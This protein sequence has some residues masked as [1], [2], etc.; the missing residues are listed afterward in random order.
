MTF[1]SVVPLLVVI[2]DS[3]P[4]IGIF[5]AISSVLI[6]PNIM[7]ITS[8]LIIE[9]I[10]FQI[11]PFNSFAFLSQLLVRK[12][13]LLV[14]VKTVEFIAFLDLVGLVIWDDAFYLFQV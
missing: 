2:I 9:L 1:F 12:G 13:I 8:S 14:V 11:H 6:Q 5:V 3:F 7:S 10:I 4:D